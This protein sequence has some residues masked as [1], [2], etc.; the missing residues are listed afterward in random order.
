MKK[1]AVFI[2]ILTLLTACNADNDICL[3]SDATP[4][5]KIK[6]KNASNN[7]VKTLDSIFVSVDFGTGTK[8]ILKQK[9]P[10]DSVL[11][12]LRVDDAPYTDIYVKL[13]SAGDSSNI[14]F[15]YT[16]KSEYVSPACGIKKSY[17]NLKIKLEKSA[18]VL[19]LEQTQNEINN[20]AKTSLYLI[21]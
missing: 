18:P 21:F 10:T 1:L 20:E 19:G 12:P 9:F 3:N 16:T 5:V 2:G 14:R 6:F 4:R 15:N 13:A 17:Q 11:I 8:S 7:K